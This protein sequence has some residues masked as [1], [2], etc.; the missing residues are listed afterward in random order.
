MCVDVQRVNAL[1][2]DNLHLS[3]SECISCGQ[4][5]NVCPTLALQENSSIDR[6]LSAIARQ[7]TL[8]LQT[9]PAVRVS[10]GEA[11]GEK[12]GSVVTGKIIGAARSMGFKH[13]IDTNWGADMTIVEEGT[14]LLQRLTH[15]GVLPQF[16]SCCPAWVNFVEK[17]HPE[18]IPHLSS[19][20]SP[21]M[22]VG[23]LVRPYF[24]HRHNIDPEDCFVV[25]L[26]PCVAKKDEIERMQVKGD[27]NAVITAR[28]FIKM[29]SMMGVD[30]VGTKPSRYDSFMGESTGGGALFGVTGGVTEA[31]VR[32]AHQVLTKQKLGRIVYNQWRGFQDL[33]EAEVS[34][35][36]MKIKIAVCNGI[37]AARDLIE[38]GRF[39][40]YQ[41]V[42]VM[43][44]KGGCICGGGQPKLRSKQVAQ[45]RAKGLFSIDDE[46]AEKVS[47]DN[48]EVTEI[49]KSFLGR[50]GSELAHKLLHTHYEPQETVYLSALRAMTS[51]EEGRALPRM[52]TDFLQGSVQTHHTGRSTGMPLSSFASPHS[53]AVSSE[54]F[55]A[56]LVNP[57][58]KMIDAFSSEVPICVNP[59]DVATL[60]KEKRAVFLITPQTPSEA[61]LSFFQDLQNSVED[62]SS[63]SYAVCGFQNKKL[64][65]QNRMTSHLDTTLEGHLAMRIV[66][67]IEID[68]SAE[69]HG[70]S[71]FERWILVLCT[72]LGLPVPQLSLSVMYKLR[73]SQQKSIV[74]SPLRP[75]TF[76][77][78]RI[79]GRTELCPEGS[80]M[81]L[82]RL[83]I[84]LPEG[85]GYRTGGAAAILPRNPPE[86]AAQVVEA[87]G[88]EPDQPYRLR[89]SQENNE[90]YIPELITT[91]QLFE[92]YIDLSCPTTR[93]LLKVFM[94]V[95]NDESRDQLRDL[96]D[97]ANEYKFQEFT[98][99]TSIADFLIQFAA[100]GCPRLESL[101]SGCPLIKARSFGISSTPKKHPGHLELVVEGHQQNMCGR[102]LSS[103]TKGHI[104]LKINDEGFD[105]P[106]DKGTPLILLSVGA[107]IG[108]V[109]GILQHR[110]YNAGPFGPAILIAQFPKKAMVT[111]I[112]PE[113][114]AFAAEKVL[115]GVIWVFEEGD[116][117]KYKS[118]MAAIPAEVRAIW[119]L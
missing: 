43:S 82:L 20:K 71:S 69:D 118:W 75:K 9:A 107:G 85:L 100:H 116:D 27:I 41:F 108:P 74:E 49:Y 62:L 36:D 51:S 113:V 89:R 55:S 78:A 106:K 96:L 31:A 42:E 84:K 102:Y 79:K 39:R 35:G 10:I 70:E 4:C 53:S 52:K 37:G 81:S 7:K 5:I 24:A 77:L 18:I 72:T 56:R 13:V 2:E 73:P 17:L 23:A 93:H 117:S 38:S 59:A 26:M 11:F 105:Y 63:V 60:V 119:P 109:L 29:V 76:E 112:E 40:D 44:C 28:E 25:S 45:T 86:L 64:K 58:N 92:Q 16:T 104:A 1:T 94:Q 97:L 30:W 47:G 68:T 101:L 61:F 65:N 48:P 32:F 95:L 8:I 54:I 83:E 22:I 110:K 14:E 3:I 66:R 50:P 19:T 87:L 91:R 15:N 88:L 111:L 114:D 80:G 115:E 98:K 99:R 6:V 67:L 33:K 34:I 12:V 103:L 57:A 90:F 21:H 46:S